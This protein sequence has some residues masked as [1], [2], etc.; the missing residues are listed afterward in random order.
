MFAEQA[1]MASEIHMTGA[2]M[3]LAFVMLSMIAKEA[4]E[5]AAQEEVRELV[6]FLLSLA[7]CFASRAIRMVMLDSQLLYL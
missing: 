1:R 2:N 5:N 4:N 7:S 6:S 3:A